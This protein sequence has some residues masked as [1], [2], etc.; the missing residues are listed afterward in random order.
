MNEISAVKNKYKIIISI[1]RYPV[2][3][4]DTF[5]LYGL[6]S[7][8]FPGYKYELFSLGKG[9]ANNYGSIVAKWGLLLLNMKKRIHREA[10]KDRPCFVTGEI[11]PAAP[12][13]R[14]ESP[15]FTNYLTVCILSSTQHFFLL[16]NMKSS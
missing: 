2:M 5:P 4:R 15:R 14:T 10:C 9:G 13:N 12:P 8:Q 3:A 6:D 7:V 16:S 1:T 11:D